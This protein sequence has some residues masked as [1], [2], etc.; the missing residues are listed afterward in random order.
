MT[1]CNT[2][3]TVG[4]KAVV[5]VRPAPAPDKDS[6]VQVKRGLERQ[7]PGEVT[8][9]CGGLWGGCVCLPEAGTMQ[10]ALDASSS[11]SSSR[12]TQ[13]DIPDSRP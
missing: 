8:D 1:A 3:G 4:Q 11:S 9:L 2:A 12:A 10:Q 5:T 6:W 7:K 13:T